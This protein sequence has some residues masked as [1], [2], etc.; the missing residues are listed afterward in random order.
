MEVNVLSTAITTQTT[1]PQMIHILMDALNAM[2]FIQDFMTLQIYT[3][4][5]LGIEEMDLVPKT[6]NRDLHLQHHDLLFVYKI[7]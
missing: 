2:E 7:K 6:T 3:T 4:L 5:H 1:A